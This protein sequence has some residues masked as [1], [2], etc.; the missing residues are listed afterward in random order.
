MISPKRPI[1]EQHFIHLQQWNESFFLPFVCGSPLSMQRGKCGRE[2]QAGV[3]SEN[4]EIQL[5]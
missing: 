5:G 1:I 4:V 3:Q 2:L